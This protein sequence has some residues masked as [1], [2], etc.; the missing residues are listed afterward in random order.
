M[1]KFNSYYSFDRKNLLKPD[2]ILGIDEVGRGCWAGPLVVCGIILKPNY[3]NEKIKDSK[4][5]SA[6]QRK[7]L[8][9][10]ILKNTVKYLILKASPLK[11]D[12]FG[13]KNCTI[14]LMTQIV[15]QL[16]DS[17]SKILID[18]EKINS[19]KYLVH[20][21]TKGDQIS[22]SIASASIVAKVYRDKLMQQLDLKY[23]NY[24]FKNH[25]GYGTKKHLISLEEYGPIKN[26][27]RFSYKPIKKLS[28]KFNVK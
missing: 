3:Y 2:L 17:V 10:D 8:S 24:Q 13:I 7:L 14:Q 28:K 19:K 16:G 26:V 27:H 18:Y 11:V 25:K 12:K 6:K 5:L 4:L 22:H 21:I 9:D 23:P 1:K 15:N 20:S